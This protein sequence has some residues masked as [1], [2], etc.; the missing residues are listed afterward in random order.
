M[1]KNKDYF[2]GTSIYADSRIE[3][4]VIY[5]F[6]YSAFPLYK[7]GIVKKNLSFIM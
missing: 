1:E 7:M 2:I 6:K 5:P 4:E 3:Y